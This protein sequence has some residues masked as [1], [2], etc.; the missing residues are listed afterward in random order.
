M[1]QV[2]A[3]WVLLVFLG[4][5][6]AGGA[7]PGPRGRASLAPRGDDTGV[8]ET[9][10]LG[11]SPLLDSASV[12][13]ADWMAV[14]AATV[15]PR[16][17]LELTLPGTHDSGA[18][19]LTPQLMPD[20]R[21]PPSWAAAAIALA[22]RLD[23][24]VDRVITPWALTQTLDV[25]NQLSAGFRYVDIRAGWNGTAW[26]AHHAEVGVEI[27]RVLRDVSDFL[28][29]HPG[30]FV[31]A[32]VSH[33]DG[34]PGEARVRDLR[35][36]I[37]E[38]LRGKLVRVG[39]DERKRTGETG[40]SGPGSD[41]DSDSDW[42]ERA[43][44][45]EQPSL[46]RTVGEMVATGERAL[47][48]FGDG[49]YA[50]RIS[51]ANDAHDYDSY[52]RTHLWPPWTLHNSYAN[53]D[54]SKAMTDYVRARVAAFAA[55]TESPPGALFK[56]SWTLTTQTRTVLESALPGRPRS[57]RELDAEAAPLLAPFASDIVSR[58]CRTGNVLS[59][60]FAERSDAVAAARAM[61]ALPVGTACALGS[62]ASTATGGR[63][64]FI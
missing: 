38:T 5:R 24:P 53:S 28:D 48:V 20:A 35:T 47:V 15:Y 12:D 3:F 7:R 29:E 52:P 50:H 54:D 11:S 13:L 31:V 19:F 10:P 17:L 42:G 23:V 9:S 51:T 2:A 43:R 46:N 34:D 22:E 6:A 37:G 30:E 56:M 64:A 36:M 61:N 60:D 55:G 25:A 8:Y 27:A 39:A 40:D 1:R 14:D 49:D 58:G 26:C 33:L 18:Y 32:Q 59:V 44:R 45:R 41:S 62:E 4:P 16:T 57:L 63:N 21:F